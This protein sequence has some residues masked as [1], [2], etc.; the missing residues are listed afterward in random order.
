[1]V[2]RVGDE[3]TLWRLFKYLDDFLTR[4]RCVTCCTKVAERSNRLDTLSHSV[5]R[6]GI[7][8]VKS[9]CNY[10]DVITL[11]APR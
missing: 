3:H 7:R 1:M 11:Y 9:G 4:Q 2:E 10:G 8:P 6:R 5:T